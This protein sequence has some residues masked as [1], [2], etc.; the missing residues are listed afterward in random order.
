MGGPSA[1]E[2]GWDFQ[3]KLVGT[4]CV[5]LAHVSVTKRIRPS[6]SAQKNGNSETT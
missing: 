2:E 6:L 3:G 5:V 1:V 4:V